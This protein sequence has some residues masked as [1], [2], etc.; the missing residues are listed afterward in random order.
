[1][2]AGGWKPAW[3]QWVLELSLGAGI[4]EGLTSVLYFVLLWAGAASRVSVLAVELAGLAIG[5]WLLIRRKREH[6]KRS[7]TQRFAWNWAIR[8][9]AALAVLLFSL[10]FGQATTANPNGEWDAFSVWNVRARFLASGPP[11]WR[12]A[13]SPD[14]ASGL[15]GASHPSYPLLVSSSVSRLWTLTGE[16]SPGEPAVVSLLFA[17]A[18]A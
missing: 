13:V 1:M 5:G 12:N 7:A 17:L 8:G 11:S 10:D 9:A 15:I 4:G 3:L 18:A 14:S 6:R 2:P 16:I